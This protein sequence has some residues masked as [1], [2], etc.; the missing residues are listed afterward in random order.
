MLA[1]CGRLLLRRRFNPRS[2]FPG[3]D[4]TAGENTQTVQGVSIHAPRFRGAM[5]T[6]GWPL[7]AGLLFQSTLPVSGER[8]ALIR[9]SRRFA[10]LVSIHAPRFRGAMQH[11]RHRFCGRWHVSI[12]APRFR[13]AMR[14]GMG[15]VSFSGGVS[16]HAPRFRGAMLPRPQKRRRPEHV[17]IHAPRFRGAMLISCNY[18]K[19]RNKKAALREPLYSR[20]NSI[21]RDQMAG[22]KSALNQSDIASA[23]LPENTR[24]LPVRARL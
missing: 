19:Y 9:C 14:V 20:A 11:G 12:H 18:R 23:N 5:R 4:A 24:P 6:K 15:A 22:G 17:S 10:S 21:L 7:K 2:P 13:G 8:C 16:I 1:A 3:S